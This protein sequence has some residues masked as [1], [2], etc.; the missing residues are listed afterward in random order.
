MNV[1]SRIG[2]RCPKRR[3][4]FTLVELL[5]VVSIIALLI[6]ILLPSLRKARTQAK[7]VVCKANLK[8]IGQAFTMYAESFKGVWPPAVDTYGL[9]NRWPVPFHQSGIIKDQLAKFDSQGNIVSGGDP[10]IFLCPEEKA[11]RAIPNWRDTGEYVDRVEVG[12]SYAVSE[13]IHRKG[14]KLERGYFP[15]PTAEPPFIN[16]IDNCRRA[17]S[18]FAVMD[19]AWPIKTVTSPGWRFHRGWNGS[20][21]ELGGSFFEGWRMTDGSD[22]PIPAFKYKRNIGDR[23]SGHGNGLMIDTHVESYRPDNVSYNQVSWD[24]WQG[25][26]E[27]VPGGK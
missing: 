10:S 2:R 1:T 19:N 25:D 15:P 5:V 17:S 12:G 21:A 3:S 6:A 20:S 14:D 24:R 23:H 4:A 26:P 7:D 16:Q 13:E 27:D 18:V 9:Q 22:I 11:D 8:S